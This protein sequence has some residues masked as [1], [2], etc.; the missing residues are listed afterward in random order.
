[1]MISD[2]NLVVGGTFTNAGG[3]PT[4]DYLAMWDGTAWHSMGSQTAAPRSTDL[5]VPSSATAAC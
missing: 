5:Y 3:D 1:M 2:V 4:A